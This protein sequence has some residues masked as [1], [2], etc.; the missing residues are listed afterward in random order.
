[1]SVGCLPRARVRPVDLLGGPGVT[2]RFAWVSML[3][4]AGSALGLLLTALAFVPTAAWERFVPL[5]T[6]VGVAGVIAASVAAA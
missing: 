6:V 4:V 2:T 1:M 5:A 3:V